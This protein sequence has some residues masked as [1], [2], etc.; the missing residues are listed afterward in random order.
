MKLLKKLL[1]AWNLQGG[2]VFCGPKGISYGG[3]R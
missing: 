3:E 2:E 1:S